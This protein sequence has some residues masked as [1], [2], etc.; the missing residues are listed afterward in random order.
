MKRLGIATSLA[1]FVG[2]VSL[3]SQVAGDV[4]TITKSDGDIR[5][6]IDCDAR[7]ESL[8]VITALLNANDK[9]DLYLLAS[10]LSLGEN[11]PNAYVF[12][13]EEHL[14]KRDSYKYA[15]RYTEPVELTSV[16]DFSSEARFILPPGEEVVVR[17]P[18]SRF[19]ILDFEKAY[20]VTSYFGFSSKHDSHTFSSKLTFDIEPSCFDHDGILWLDD[21]QIKTQKMIPR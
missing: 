5:V 15:A 16:S 18:V 8:H 7:S 9:D 14:H 4:S 21:V 19:Y 3:A 10:E 11:V 12:I 1:F 20:R 17:D 6:G 13:P 2:A